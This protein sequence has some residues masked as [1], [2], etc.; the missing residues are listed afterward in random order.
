MAFHTLKDTHSG[1]G[2]NSNILN[3]TIVSQSST[4]GLVRL[5]FKSS[6]ADI[7]DILITATCGNV[8]ICE[9]AVPVSGDYNFPQYQVAV[10][11]PPNTPIQLSTT[12]TGAGDTY[13]TILTE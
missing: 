11:C 8:V 5:G 7:A 2:T 6:T 4:S 9:N 12:A 10:Q 3:N 13:F 1:A